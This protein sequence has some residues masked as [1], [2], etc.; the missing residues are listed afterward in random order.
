PPA[1]GRPPASRHLVDLRGTIR[2]FFARYYVVFLF[3]RD[4]R[5]RTVS[6]E[7]DRRRRVNQLGEQIALGMVLASLVVCMLIALYFVKSWLGIDIIPG[8]HAWEIFD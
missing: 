5:T 2:L 8:R 7:H 3:G 1:Q 4:R 6:T